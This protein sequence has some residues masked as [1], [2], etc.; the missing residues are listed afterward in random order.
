MYHETIVFI[1]K[2]VAPVI[3]AGFIVALPILLHNVPTGK[4]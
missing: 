1:A 3:T 2:W 4:H